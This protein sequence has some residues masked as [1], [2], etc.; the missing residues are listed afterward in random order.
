MC[1]IAFSSISVLLQSTR[2]FRGCKRA[3]ISRNHF[4]RHFTS[5]SKS[6]KVNYMSQTSLY[7]II[8][9][10][11]TQ[12]KAVNLYR[13]DLNT[14]KLESNRVNHIFILSIYLIVRTIKSCCICFTIKRTCKRVFKFNISIKWE[15]RTR[16]INTISKST[17]KSILFHTHH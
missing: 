2:K 3:S 7:K 5:C 11:S 17:S 16:F 13:N 1:S 12:I 6:I 4:L 8:L 10:Q 15:N 9:K 14:T